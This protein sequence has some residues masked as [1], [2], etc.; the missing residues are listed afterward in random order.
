M[1]GVLLVPIIL[2]SQE[3]QCVTGISQGQMPPGGIRAECP[4]RV[5]RGGI[6]SGLKKMTVA[7]ASLWWCIPPSSRLHCDLNNAGQDSALG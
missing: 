2:I 3:E 4:Q 1:S 6:I 7:E 5:R